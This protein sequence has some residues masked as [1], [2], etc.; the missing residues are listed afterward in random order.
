MP[1]ALVFQWHGWNE[2]SSRNAHVAEKFVAEGYAVFA[3]DNRGQVR[4]IERNIT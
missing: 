1:R 3:L 4:E 2:H